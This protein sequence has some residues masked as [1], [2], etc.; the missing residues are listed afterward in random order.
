MAVQIRRPW[1]VDELLHVDNLTGEIFTTESNAHEF[2]ICG[3]DKDGEAIPI[4]G[5]ISGAFLRADG[6]TVPINAG[7]LVDGEAH[8][9]LPLSLIHI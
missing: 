1:R 6:A 8:I 9:I 4:T 2:V 7:T 3:V 5:T